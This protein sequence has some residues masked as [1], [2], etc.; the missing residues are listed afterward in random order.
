MKFVKYQHVERLGTDETEG[1]LDG[2]VYVFPKI[3]GTNG[4][5]WNDSGVIC[6]G[7]RSKM[8][9]DNDDNRGF[10]QFVL[11]KTGIPAL[12]AE[13]P[14]RLYGEWLVPHTLKTY[15]EEAW[16]KFYVFDVTVQENGV[17]KYLPYDMYKSVLDEYGIEYIPCIALVENGKPEIFTKLLEQNTYLIKE[18]IGEGLVIK[19]YDFVNKW[20]RIVWA[21]TVTNEFK[22]GHYKAMGAPKLSGGAVIEEAIVNEFVTLD[23]VNKEYSTVCNNH[24][25]DTNEGPWSS[26][27]I[28]ELLNRTYHALVTEELWHILKKFKVH[29][30]IDFKLLERLC[31]AK[32][33]ELKKELF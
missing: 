22:F 24:A 21:K 7:T 12:L 18:G 5:V 19:R 26:R 14:W 13:Y 28:P 30:I 25:E 11:E 32:V 4:S 29:P 2:T 3:D 31:T 15:K 20:G 10:K 27:R 1:I 6:C 23:L 33:K 8:L 17:E 9:G 16:N